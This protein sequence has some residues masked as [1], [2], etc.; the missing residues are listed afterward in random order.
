[1]K[2][3]CKLKYEQEITRHEV[4]FLK[5]RLSS[6]IASHPFRSQPIAQSSLIDSI[7]N[8]DLRQQLYKQ[9]KSVAEQARTTMMNVY[10]E[11]AEGQMSQS[12]KQFSI[13]M[14]EMWK[15]N[16]S[17]PLDQ[18]FTQVMLNLIDQRLANITAR[19][20]CVYKFKTDLL[21]VKSNTH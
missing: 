7:N 6:H 8:S 20:K 21:H 11:S 17:L 15:V 19:I 3:L 4:H 18:Q 5:Q 12:D 14:N 13:E 10:M 2:R 16:K 1:M 9:Y